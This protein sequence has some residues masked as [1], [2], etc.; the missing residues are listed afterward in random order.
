MRNW[1]RNDSAKQVDQI[2]DSNKQVDAIIN[3]SNKQVDAISDSKKVVVTRSDPS[4]DPRVATYTTNRNFTQK[5]L[6]SRFVPKIIPVVIR[7]INPSV[8]PM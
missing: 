4:S 3:D 2:N 7:P 8:T 5:L 6:I 1:L